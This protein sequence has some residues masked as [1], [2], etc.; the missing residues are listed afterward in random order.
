MENSA[1]FKINLFYFM[2]W[3]KAWKKSWKS[4]CNSKRFCYDNEAISF[5]TPNLFLETFIATL[6]WTH[7]AA[8]NWFFI[9]HYCFVCCNFMAWKS[10][11]N[12]RMCQQI[13][14]AQ[15]NLL[16]ASASIWNRNRSSW[17]MKLANVDCDKLYN[18]TLQKTRDGQIVY[19]W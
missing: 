18:K 19:I 12:K 11:A 7:A 17:S 3:K 15:I 13:I 1:L 8:K 5:T 2:T 10:L 16:S 4:R 14:Y 9:F 6:I